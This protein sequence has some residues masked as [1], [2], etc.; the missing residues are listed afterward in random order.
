ML[1]SAFGCEKEG[2]LKTFLKSSLKGKM[3]GVKKQNVVLKYV[4][5]VGKEV[6]H[7]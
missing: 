4:I 6:N 1:I 2:F 7:E 3:K 5:G